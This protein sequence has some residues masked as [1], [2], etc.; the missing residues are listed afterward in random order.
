MTRED[1]AK[2]AVEAGFRQSDID[3]A[4]RYVDDADNVWL[5]F[6]AIVARLAKDHREV[7]PH[8]H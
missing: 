4:W 7:E 1:I 6:A 8:G 5:R 2:A 3:I